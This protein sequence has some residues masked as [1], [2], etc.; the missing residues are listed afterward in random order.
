MFFTGIK[1]KNRKIYRLKLKT[2]INL[3]KNQ[4]YI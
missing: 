2:N 1:I 3:Y 4:K